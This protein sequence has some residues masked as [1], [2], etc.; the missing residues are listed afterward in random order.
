MSEKGNVTYRLI[1]HIFGENR[2]MLERLAYFYVGSREDAQD[3]VSQSFMHLW[4]KRA[5]ILEDRILP[6]LFTTVKNACLD[7]RRKASIH[8]QTHDQLQRQERSMMEIYTSTI[9]SRDPVDLFTD[10]ILSIYKETLLNLPPQE[11]EVW[12]RNRIDGLTYKEIAAALGITYK[13][14][15]KDMQKVMKK[16]KAALSEYLSL[17]LILSSMGMQL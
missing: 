5:E 10:E 13:R 6:Y 9:E 4:E 8:K 12:L 3:I 15:D 11:R 14:V 17:F 16:L 2:D 1:E 7:F